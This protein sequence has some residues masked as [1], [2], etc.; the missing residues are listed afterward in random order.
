MDDDQP[1]S[2]FGETT[3]PHLIET[4]NSTDMDIPRGV[5]EVDTAISHSTACS[6]DIHFV[7]LKDM[8]S[9][10]FCLVHVSRFF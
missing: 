5:P 1:I 10:L 2:K 8:F 9:L 4:R 7:E 3:H 6:N